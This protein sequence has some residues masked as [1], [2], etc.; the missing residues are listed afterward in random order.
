MISKKMQDAIN[1][2]IKLEFYSANLYLSMSAYM[3]GKN[4]KGIAHWLK[5]QYE[6][7]TF[8]ALKLY[9][10]MNSR[11]GQVVM[12]SVDAPPVDFGSPL[13]TFEQV[14]KHEQEITGAIHKLYKVAVEENDFA[15]QI[16][17]QWYITE[18]MEEEASASEVIGKM[19][20]I[21]DSGID[22]LYL[23]NELSSR[24]FVPPAANA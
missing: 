8:H 3:E 13:E 2:Q 22:L 5:V 23:D 24:V 16:F 7:E 18:Q 11:E 4:L 10:Y 14:L 12:P 1:E 15:A 9:D 17:L 20:L 19:K 6:E 21:G